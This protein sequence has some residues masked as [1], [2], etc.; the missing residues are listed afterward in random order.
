M[1]I[2]GEGETQAEITVGANAL[3]SQMLGQYEEQERGLRLEELSSLRI[4][5]DEIR[6]SQKSARLGPAS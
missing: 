2:S 1:H 3:I 6:E 4:G 5:E